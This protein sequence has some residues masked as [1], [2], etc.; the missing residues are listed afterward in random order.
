[1]HVIGLSD[2]M[3]FILAHRNM[4]LPVTHPSDRQEYVPQFQPAYQIYKPSDKMVEMLT[5]VLGGGYDSSTAEVTVLINSDKV[6][7]SSPSVLQ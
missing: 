2:S 4:C 3:S 6:T 1:M 7:Q 5:V